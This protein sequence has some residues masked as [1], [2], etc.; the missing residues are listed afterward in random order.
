MLKTIYSEIPLSLRN[1]TQPYSVLNPLRWT[2]LTLRSEY[3]H[4]LFPWRHGIPGRVSTSQF[5]FEPFTYSSKDYISIK[6]SQKDAAGSSSPRRRRSHVKAFLN[7]FIANF[8]IPPSSPSRRLRDYSLSIL[9]LYISSW[10][11]LLPPPV[12]VWGWWENNSRWMAR[13]RRRHRQ[14]RQCEWNHHRRQLKAINWRILPSW[15]SRVVG[16]SRESVFRCELESWWGWNACLESIFQM[17]N[18]R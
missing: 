12:Y 10:L 18:T 1:P 16:G 6:A 7:N 2:F 14:L 11:V 9:L 17:W 4:P 15:Q 5:I 3:M 8:I 13:T